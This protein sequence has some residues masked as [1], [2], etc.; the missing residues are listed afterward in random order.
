MHSVERII[1]VGGHFRLEIWT[2][3]PVV[4]C[5]T[6]GIPYNS[7]DKY[8]RYDSGWE[9]NLVT[10]AGIAGLASRCNGN[11]AEAVFNYLAVGTDATAA[12][13]GN[14]ALGAEITD[15]G[16]ARAVAT[17]A[18]EDT[19]GGVTNGSATWTYTWTASGSKTIGE[20]GI[21]NAASTGTLLARK[22]GY[23][24]AVS[25]GEDVTGSYTL[26]FAA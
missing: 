4:V 21:L 15:S 6:G 7:V 24:K 19:G 16:L 5:H 25:S 17:V 14:T 12:A 2:P 10:D 13:A 23:S 8:R 11:G 20:M 18:R 9:P 1:K 26:P 22:G 3:E